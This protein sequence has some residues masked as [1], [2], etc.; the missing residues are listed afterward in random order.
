MADSL[1]ERII[2]GGTILLGIVGIGSLLLTH[3]SNVTNKETLVDVQRAFV[4]LNGFQAMKIQDVNRK[5]FGWS[6]A[7][8]WEN[9]GTTPTRNLRIHVS[10]QWRPDALPD[11]FGFP[12]L[13]SDPQ[14][15]HVEIPILLGPKATIAGT[16]ITFAP[17]LIMKVNTRQEHIYFWGWATYRDVFS[18]TPMH[19]TKFCQE[20]TGFGDNPFAPIAVGPIPITLSNC[21]H[22]NCADE[23]CKQNR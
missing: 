18:K 3:S 11:N 9:S 19:V 7:P 17:D 5:V 13:W 20:L 1:T 22:N 16:S 23:E 12:D 10:S 14:A 8:V 4:F 2:A 21:N 6:F 15:P